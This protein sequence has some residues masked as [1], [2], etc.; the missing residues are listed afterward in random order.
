MK[1]HIINSLF[2]R[3]LCITAIISLLQGCTKNFEEYNTDKTQ[4]MSVGTKEL[5]GLFTTAQIEGSNWLSTDNYNR[6]SRTITNHLSGYMCVIDITYEQNVLNRSYH[7]S[8]YTGIYSKAIPPLQCIFDITKDKSKYQNE[9]AIALIW[10]VFLLHQ[11]TDLF[12]PI[13]YTDAGTGKST[14][15]FQSQKDVYYLMFDDLKKSI[16][17]LTSSVASDPSANAFGAGDM[18]YNGKVIEWLKFANTLRL[19]L[20][21]RISNID[22]T[23]AQEEAEAAAAGIT[24]DA[25]SDDAMLAV[26][27]WN[28]MGNGLSRVNPWY[29]SLMS[30]SME[31]FLKGYNDPRMEQYFSRVI[32]SNVS[33]TLPAELQSNIG[34]FHGMA[35]GYKTAIEGGTNYCYSNLNTTRWSAD[36]K[37]TQPL[38]II[39]SA[40]TYFLKAEGAWRGW[41]MGGSSAQSFYESGIGVSMTQWTTISSDSIQKY[42]ASENTP[43]APNDYLYYHPATSDIPVKFSGDKEKQFEQIITQKWLAMF[44]ISVEAFAE[45]RRTRYPKI[46]PKEY[47]AN[48]NIDISQGMI[49]TRLPFPTSE[50]INQPEEIAKAILLLGNGV[51]E[52]LENIPLWWDTNK[53]GSVSPKF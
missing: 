48:A 2:V 29:S 20:A 45:Y 15:T 34:G 32:A 46:Y 25:N 24:M 13:P 47:S 39:Y 16:D 10:K 21:M 3:V 44:P 19:R 49:I 38:P 22:A 50:G 51:T 30:A 33:S 17:I 31:S 52:D 6:I 43:V 35:N 1:K 7:N 26:V 18:I 27:K 42:I 28:T 11:V 5:A 36:T 37:L 14:T 9:Y 41:N 4:L 8:G 40:E 23:K 53:N 12:G